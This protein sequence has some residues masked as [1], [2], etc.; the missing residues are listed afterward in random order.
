M[1]NQEQAQAV[2]REGLWMARRLNQPIDKMINEDD[3]RKFISR[4][5]EIFPE[6]EVPSK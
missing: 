6:T 5:P 1:G 4:Y 2:M 3:V